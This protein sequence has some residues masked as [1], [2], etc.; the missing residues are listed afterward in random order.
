MQVEL[1]V[2]QEQA[3]VVVWSSPVKCVPKVQVAKL[4]Q[5]F[6]AKGQVWAELVYRLKWFRTMV[7]RKPKK[8]PYLW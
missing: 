1:R 5:L 6:A 2:M 7:R 3:A 4:K 8:L